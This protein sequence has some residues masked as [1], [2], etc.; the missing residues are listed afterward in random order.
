ML[1]TGVEINSLNSYKGEYLYRGSSINKEEIDKIKKYKDNGKL[2]SIVVFSK[3]F[4]SFSEDENEAR[5]FCG[6]SDDK[7]IGI[8][9]ILENNDINSHQSR[10]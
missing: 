8:L 9:F 1:Y 7:K 3:A 4:L 10:Y 6:H 5:K 2:S